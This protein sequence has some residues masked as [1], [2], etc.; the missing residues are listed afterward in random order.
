MSIY[1]KLVRDRIPKIIKRSDKTFTSRILV[2]DE[3]KLEINKK[4]MRN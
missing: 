3:Y 2:D 1:N 4:Y